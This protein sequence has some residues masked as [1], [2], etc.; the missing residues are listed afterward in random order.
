MSE[1]EL[2]PKKAGLGKIV[3]FTSLMLGGMV[4]GEQINPLHSMK[5]FVKYYNISA[6]DGTPQD[7]R[8]YGTEIM[9]NEKGRAELYFGNSET[10]EYRLVNEDGTVGNVGLKID[11]YFGKKKQQV[12]NWYEKLKIKNYETE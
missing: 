7:Y 10:Q 2:K 5:D 4:L 12:K 9:I 11:E 8:V 6:E 1:Q 3:L